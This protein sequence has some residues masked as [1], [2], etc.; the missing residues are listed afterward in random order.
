MHHNITMFNT[1]KTSAL[2]TSWSKGRRTSWKTKTL[3][4]I[5]ARG[6]METHYNRAV[7]EPPGLS[8]ATG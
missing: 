4:T 1:G 8:S 6:S 5:V 3:I 7:G 2:L